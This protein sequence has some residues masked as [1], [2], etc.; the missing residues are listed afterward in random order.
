[1]SLKELASFQSAI[2][3]ENYRRNYLKLVV[4]LY[5]NSLSL[6]YSS[7]TANSQTINP[8]CLFF[9]PLTRWGW[10]LLEMVQTP[11]EDFCFPL[12][13]LERFNEH[14]WFL[15]LGLL[16]L[17]AK[18]QVAAMCLLMAHFLSMTFE[19]YH[20]ALVFKETL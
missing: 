9:E 4:C 6:D 2:L 14:R 7:S 19:V 13:L 20:L 11:L 16:L 18:G 15:L 8:L 17:T 1:L 3:P 12:Y 5:L 10:D